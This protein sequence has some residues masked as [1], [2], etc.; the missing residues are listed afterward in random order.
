MDIYKYETRIFGL[1]L[2]SGSNYEESKKVENWAEIRR[3]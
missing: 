3:R 2:L 1:N